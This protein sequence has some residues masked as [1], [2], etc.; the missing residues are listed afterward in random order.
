MTEKKRAEQI[1]SELIEGL[2]RDIRFGEKKHDVKAAARKECTSSG[3]T[4]NAYL[5]IKGLFSYRSFQTYCSDISTF[6]NWAASNT[7]AKDMA[8]AKQYVHKYLKELQSRGLSAY[9][10]KKY[11]HALARAYGGDI[12]DFGIEFEKRLRKNITRSRKAVSSDSRF[13]GEKYEDARRFSRAT[14]AR[15]GGMEKIR[16]CDIRPREQGG[17]EVFLDEKG[18]KTRWA[19]VLPEYED[20]VLSRFSKARKHGETARLFPKGALDHHIDIHACRAEYARAAYDRY[21]AEGY[22]TGRL[23]RCRNERYGEVYDKG[24]LLAVSRDLGHSRCDVVV[25]N[26]LR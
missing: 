13:T 17:Y 9:T 4:D 10:I 2:R 18:G 24:V 3:G 22:A 16:A 5:H 1:R 7:N 11:A 26:Y 20:F 8:S 25:N 23:Y 12:S 15:Y 21:E 19:R 6:A 14:G